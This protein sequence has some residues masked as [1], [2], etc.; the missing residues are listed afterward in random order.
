MG[1]P[2]TKIDLK[3]QLAALSPAKRAL[4]ELKLMKRNGSRKA[5]EETIPRRAGRGPPP[6]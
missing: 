4:L 6:Q 2:S 3:Q 1:V 5:A